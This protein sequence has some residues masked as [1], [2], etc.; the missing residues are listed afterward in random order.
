VAILGKEVWIA[1]LKGVPESIVVEGIQ[2]IVSGTFY[3]AAVVEFKGVVLIGF[4]GKISGWE[5][6]WQATFKIVAIYFLFSIYVSE[7]SP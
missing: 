2:R 5:K 6:S 1:S 3:S 7:F 4:V